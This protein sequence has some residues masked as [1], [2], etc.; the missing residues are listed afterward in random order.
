MKYNGALIDSLAVD[1]SQEAGC[2]INILRTA[3]RVAVVMNGWGWLG[4]ICCDA[5]GLV[6]SPGGGGERA[7]TCR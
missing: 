2:V 6:R 4:M 5:G 3:H 7:I 1:G